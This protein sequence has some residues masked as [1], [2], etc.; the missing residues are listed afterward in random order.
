M[1]AVHAGRPAR[2]VGRILRLVLGVGLVWMT[3]AVMRTEDAVFNLRVAA[4]VAG[5]TAL[6]ALAHMAIVKYLPGINP[7]LG[8]VVA[9]TPVILV[10][11]LGGPLGRVA[12][13]AFIGISLVVQGVRGDGGCEVMS[14]PGVLFGR[15]T[16][17]VCIAFSPIDW[18]EERLAGSE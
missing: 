15:R 7:W 2:I 16:H 5:L 11:L 13:V 4:F 12:S 3:Y 8:A 17:L 6:Y 9:V 14:I 10:Y 1:T 18:L